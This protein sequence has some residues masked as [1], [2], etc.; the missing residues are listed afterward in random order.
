VR[1]NIAQFQLPPN[2]MAHVRRPG[3]PRQFRIDLIAVNLDD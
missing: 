3:F 2:L 1:E